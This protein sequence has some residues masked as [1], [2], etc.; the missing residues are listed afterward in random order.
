MYPISSSKPRTYILLLSIL[1][2]CVWTGPSVFGQN[3]GGVAPSKQWRIKKIP[4]A[5]IVF[6]PETR[7][8]ADSI[9]QTI[10]A[11][12]AYPLLPLGDHREF[13]HI[14]LRN[15]NLTANGFVGYMP[16]RSEFFVN[17]APDPNAIGY[18]DW[19]R[20]LGLHE[21]RHAIQYSAMRRGLTGWLKNIFGEGAQA[22]VYNLLIPNWYSEGDAVFFETAASD[23]GR[24][25]L[26][27]FS[28]DMNALLRSDLNYS[29]GKFRNG[30]FRDRVPDHY[31][32]GY[33]LTAYG[34]ENYSDQ[35]WP[36]ILRETADLKGLFTPFAKSIRRKTGMKIRDFHREALDHFR[37]S[38]P[39]RNNEEEADPLFFQ[40]SPIVKNEVLLLPHPA[41][42]LFLLE[43][44]YDEIPVVY[45]ITGAERV[46][47]F[48]LGNTTDSYMSISHS[49]I[50]F[51]SKTVH[52]RWTNREYGDLFYY[53][54]EKDK[55]VSVTRK[56]K[57]LSADF[58]ESHRRYIATEAREDGQSQL[59]LYEESSGKT[60]TLMADNGTYYSYPKWLSSETSVFI[61][62]GRK[63][64]RM[65]LA[66]YDL[67]DGTTDTL[68]SPVSASI[69]RPFPAENHIYFSSGIS[70]TDDIYRTDTATGK[71][72]KLTGSAS[73]AY[74]PTTDGQ[75]ILYYSIETEKG[76]RICSRVLPD[77]D[78]TAAKETTT[79]SVD[80]LHPKPASRSDEADGIVYRSASYPE[81]EYKPGRHLLH[82]HSLFL[83]LSTDQP[84]LS[85]LSN[86]YLNTSRA[87]IYG[88]Y[89]DADKS[90]Q[91]G[92]SFTYAG[93][94]PELSIDGWHRWNRRLYFQIGND[95]Y[96]IPKSETGGEIGWAIPW[97]LSARQYQH[98]L[99][100][101][102]RY[103]LVQE[104]FNP[105]HPE[106]PGKID[107]KPRLFQTSG[108]QAEWVI[109]RMQ[110]YRDI[111]PKWG[112]A[113]LVTAAA[114]HTPENHGLI[115]LRQSF[116][117]PGFF[118]NDGFKLKWQG[119][120]NSDL[121][122]SFI[123]SRLVSANRLPL[124][125]SRFTSGA[126]F[127]VNYLFPL[128]YPEI[129]LP[130]LL[131]TKRIAV[132]IFTEHFVSNLHRQTWS[133]LDIFLTARAFHLVDFTGGIRVSRTWPMKSGNNNLQIVFL[134][135]L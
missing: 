18:G 42:R 117:L 61:F 80:F 95:V 114:S 21:Y 53:D 3:F 15:E 31:I 104:H 44:G 56:R 88:R 72:E 118:K 131:Y 49:R 134:Q 25:R 16:F 30:S 50:T 79:R 122:A 8:Q 24:G 60:D 32:H 57:F 68:I 110:A 62:T 98:I 90:W 99:R 86:D 34:Y 113:T 109:Q 51:L 52:P 58:Q 76:K 65:F 84:S 64:G 22:A 6:D 81:K 19:I 13:L 40:E 116:Y 66:S 74:N 108:I 14:T 73:G 29:Y 27:A 38:L 20:L 7:P 127:T 102:G 124:D 111:F 36:Q 33:L 41:G 47:K 12:N 89:F 100:F 69:S 105:E 133:G 11:I 128:A 46:K 67:T 10:S 132:N 94:Y 23:N 82:F 106:L 45:E 37:E 35:F 5:E 59:V 63:Q 83:D 48:A 87:E 17:A 43:S 115:Y 39:G 130:H 78:E 126:L 112:A 96:S 2:F 121:A 125:F 119:Q 4:E 135:D 77:R 123:S 55:I 54:I 75:G 1:F 107:L 129:N 85:L 97:N 28:A 93:W 92:A 101:S 9:L 26:P 120:R 91:S 71:T 70:G 103:G